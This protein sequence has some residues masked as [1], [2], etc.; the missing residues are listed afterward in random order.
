[1]QDKTRQD[2]INQCKMIQYKTRRGI[3]TQDKANKGNNI[4]DK[5]RYI[6]EWRGKTRQGNIRQYRT[7]NIIQYKT[8]QYNT[9]EDTN[10]K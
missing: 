7:D 8:R 9:R 3:T 6:N 4:Y 2:N 1:M 5:I 10:L